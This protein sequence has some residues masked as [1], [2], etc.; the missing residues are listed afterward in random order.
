MP[1]VVRAQPSVSQEFQRPPYWLLCGGYNF[2]L[3]DMQ[4]EEEG[5]PDQSQGIWCLQVNDAHNMTQT[6]TRQRRRIKHI[7][8]QKWGMQRYLKR[9]LM[10]N[11]YFAYVYGNK[12]TPSLTQKVLL[13]CSHCSEKL[14]LANNFWWFLPAVIFAFFSYNHILFEPINMYQS[15]LF[16]LPWSIISC[17]LEVKTILSYCCSWCLVI[18]FY[19]IHHYILHFALLWWFILF[20]FGY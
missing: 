5:S 1:L 11:Q 2:L 8:K 20:R 14:L 4:M 18:K 16:L 17:L 12:W 15:I 3:L 13:F 10:K 6:E 9:I 19:Q 7:N